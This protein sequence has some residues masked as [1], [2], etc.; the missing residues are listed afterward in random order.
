MRFSS[1]KTI[2]M[3]GALACLV[4]GFGQAVSAAAAAPSAD[5]VR[6]ADAIP[7][8]KLVEGAKGSADPY[9]PRVLM[10]P[11]GKK[12]ALEITDN[13]G[14]CA[15]VTVFPGLGVNGG[16]VCARVPVGQTRRIVVRAPKP[17]HYRYH[18]SENMFFGEVVA[19]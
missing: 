13:I 11:A 19:R 17:G 5:T 2:A 9:T 6:S 14:G 12:V 15:L 7:V 8:F 16:T 3:T 4:A 10:I 18:C 1:V